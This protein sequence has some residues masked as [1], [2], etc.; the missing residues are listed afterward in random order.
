MHTHEGGGVS[1]ALT[2]QLEELTIQPIITSL[3]SGDLDLAG[4]ESISLDKLDMAFEEFEEGM[5][6]SGANE[7]AEPEIEVGQHYD[8]EHLNATLGNS[9]VIEVEDNK[10]VHHSS[11]GLLLSWD[12]DSL[13][14]MAGLT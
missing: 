3:Y 4:P 10:R 2:K 9:I 11:D 1:E 7:N 13:A 6:E 5:L 8:L 12:V 14:A